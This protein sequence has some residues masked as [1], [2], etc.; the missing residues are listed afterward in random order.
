MLIM[1]G[2]SPTAKKLKELMRSKGLIVREIS[3]ITDI[4]HGTISSWFSGRANF[5]MSK[6]A[7]RTYAGQIAKAIGCDIKEVISDADL[8][9]PKSSPLAGINLLDILLD[10]IE[11]PQSPAEQKRTAKQTIREWLKQI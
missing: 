11:N 8:E 2:P 6:P 10:V 1:I 4:P 9:P 3:A 5:D 7:H